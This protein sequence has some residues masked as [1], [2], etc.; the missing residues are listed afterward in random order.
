MSCDKHSRAD[1]YFEQLAQ[2]IVPGSEKI[3]KCG[4][5]EIFLGKE[6]SCLPCVEGTPIQQLGFPPNSVDLMILIVVTF[7]FWIK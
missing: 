6:R 4:H 1:I 7:V 3:D 5:W 2:S